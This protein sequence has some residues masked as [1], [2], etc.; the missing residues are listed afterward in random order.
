MES[1]GIAGAGVMGLGIAQI[2]AI[3]GMNVRV[4]DIGEGVAAG[5]CARLET[6]LRGLAAKGRLEPHAVEAAIGR[7]QPLTEMSG[8]AGCDVIVEAIVENLE[9]KRQFFKQ[10]EE[11]VG[12]NCILASN[13]SS[14][15]I[16]AIASACS[17]PERVI[18]FHF[19]NPVPLMRI[20]E[21]IPGELTDAAVTAS[22]A[23]LG[24]RLGHRSVVASDT[25]GFIVNHA[26]RGYGTEAVKI[27]QEGVAPVETIDRI[28]RAAG[29][30]M[31]P[32]ELLDLTGLDVSHPAMETIYEQFY[33]EP[34]F[35]PSYLLRRRYKA[36]LFGRKSGSGFYRYGTDAPGKGESHPEAAVE[37]T[38][39]CPV[40]VW[41]EFPDWRELLTGYVQE[42][43][44]FVDAGDMP[45]P[46][47]LCLVAPAG[48]DATGTAL[49]LG[50]DP[51]HVVAVDLLG[52]PKLHTIM[53][54]PV[55]EEK[56]VA[57]ARF[58]LS[59]TGPV[60]EINDSYGFVGQ[61]VLAMIVNIAAEMAQQRIAMPRDIDAAVKLGL[62]Y[63]FGPLEWGDTLGTHRVL[64]ITRAMFAE[65]GDP[66]YRPS[67]W[68]VRRD[69]LGLSLHH[70]ERIS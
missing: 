32:F 59:A 13:T 54:T 2:A 42:Q 8:L 66:R 12:P 67:S 55:A 68:L 65:T 1:L 64:A 56:Y 45:G 62:G 31:G 44:F 52:L 22:M 53:T 60:V 70:P 10:V 40:W 63:P 21:V 51:A 28:L 23:A 7:L 19:F 30:R 9:V 4:F 39:P 15:S 41:A 14:H 17:K 35:R 3:A 5:A 43:G 20:V 57:A 37:R 47:S 33:G 27:L 6:T 34:R 24:Q 26:G 11:I 49:R 29:F 16:T 48:G 25:P 46:G 58:L 38:A 36:G 50:I 61:R 69:R 18:G